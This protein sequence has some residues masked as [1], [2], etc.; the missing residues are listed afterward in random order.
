[1]TTENKINGQTINNE[2][3]TALYCRL[4]VEDIKDYKGNK[5]SKEAESNSIAYQ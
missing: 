1:M 3:I 4:S 5:K 2:L